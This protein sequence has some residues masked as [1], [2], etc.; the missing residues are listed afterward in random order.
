MRLRFSGYFRNFGIDLGGGGQAYKLM[1]AAVETAAGP[2]AM[3]A[4]LHA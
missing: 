2:A 3:I 1:A 4:G